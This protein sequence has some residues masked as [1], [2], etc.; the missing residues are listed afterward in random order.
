M[1]I[2][3]II[4]EKYE[5]QDPNR[6]A[7]YVDID[8]DQYWIATN[9]H[10]HRD[11]DLPAIIRDDGRQY[12]YHDGKKHRETGPAFIWSDGAVEFWLNNYEY[13]IEDWAEKV[14]MRKHEMLITK[15][16]LGLD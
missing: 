5:N 10:L 11:G 15:H 7:D 8:G 1:K 9:G 3:Q 13:S 2:S 6:P 12:W 4:T 14:G 16:K